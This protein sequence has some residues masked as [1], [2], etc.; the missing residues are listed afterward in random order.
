M[1]RGFYFASSAAWNALPVHF[2]GA[3]PATTLEPRV[4]QYRRTLTTFI[5]HPCHLLD[6]YYPEKQIK[7]TPKDPDFIIPEIKCKLR[8]KNKLMRKGRTEEAGRMAE[9]IGKDIARRNSTSL[10]HINQLSGTK[11][12]WDAVRKLIKRKQEDQI[13]SGLNA[14]TLNKYYASIST[15]PTLHSTNKKV[16]RDIEWSTLHQIRT[17]QVPG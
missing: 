7:I 3:Y 2:Y 14:T 10:R 15:D 13:P 4:A 16:K 17:I 9:Q 8:I 6:K 1:K 12:L 5:K 11:E